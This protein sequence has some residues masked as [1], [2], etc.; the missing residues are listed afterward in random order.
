MTWL[1]A[2]NLRF[3]KPRVHYVGCLGLF[4]RFFYAYHISSSFCSLGLYLL[5]MS[6]RLM[7]L[8]NVE[9]LGLFTCI[10]CEVLYA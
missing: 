10:K 5:F 8:R 9:I 2:Y 7:F 6:N 3:T 1:N 4:S